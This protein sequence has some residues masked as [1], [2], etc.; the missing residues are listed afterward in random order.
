MTPR[1]QFEEVVTRALRNRIESVRLSLRLGGDHLQ[2]DRFE[3]S[4]IRGTSSQFEFA[5][6]S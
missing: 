3:V 6:I 2:A 1:E 5:T 4:Q